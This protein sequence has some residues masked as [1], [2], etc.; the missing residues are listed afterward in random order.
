MFDK[1]ADDELEEIK[2]WVEGSKNELLRNVLKDGKFDT[3]EDQEILM[4]ETLRYVKKIL[5]FYKISEFEAYQ[6][7][8]VLLLDAA[9]KDVFFGECSGNLKSD[10]RKL[11]RILET[12]FERVRPDS[13]LEM[14]VS[15]C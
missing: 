4:V 5:S 12:S 11:L 1:L 14:V 8:L 7:W 6:N 15:R 2:A 13:V 3:R 9:F 10:F